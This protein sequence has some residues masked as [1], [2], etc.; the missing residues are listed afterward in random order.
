VV[1][2]LIRASTTMAFAFGSGA[3]AVI[4]CESLEDAILEKRRCAGRLAGG[5]RGGLKPDGF[6]LGNSPSEYTCDRV[7]GR[8]IAFTTTNGTLAMRRA[9]LAHR[10]LVGSFANLNAVVEY[11]LA[12]ERA[13][14]AVHI[15]CAGVNNGPSHADT[16]CA[17]AFASAF[18]SARPE[19]RFDSGARAAEA[20]W[21]KHGRTM[22]GLQEALKDSPG[23]RNL[24]S[25]GLLRDL[26]AVLAWDAHAV[27]PE[28]DPAS[29]AILNVRQPG[30]PPRVYLARPG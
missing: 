23:G 9:G 28:L 15:V 19:Y 4:P 3:V 21:D 2:D 18:L 11:A 14:R 17:G 29:C 16:L 13:D 22:R 10:L 20:E 5:E 1:V 8:I 12:P 26:S 25:V 30:P 7:R 27:V 24:G 6:D